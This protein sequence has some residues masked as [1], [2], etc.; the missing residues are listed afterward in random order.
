MSVSQSVIATVAVSIQLTSTLAN[1][2]IASKFTESMPALGAANE[3]FDAEQA[4]RIVGGIPVY[5]KIPFM[6]SLNVP[7]P[8][9][10]S[11]YHYCGGSLINKDWVLTAAH[12]VYGRES[13]VLT[14]QVHVGMNSQ[15]DRDYLHTSKIS[16]VVVHPNYNSNYITNDIALLRLKDSA[17]SDYSF[18][19]LNQ[20]YSVPAD[21]ADV[22]YVGW[23]WLVDQG[24]VVPDQLQAVKVDA[25][26]TRICQYVYG[27][28]SVS[29][30]NVCTYTPDKGACQG[31]SGGPLM[32]PGSD[33]EITS[34][35]QVGIVS[36][37]QKCAGAGS[38]TVTTRVSQYMDWIEYTVQNN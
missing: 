7:N 30:N 31:D 29:S 17:P 21:N 32:A 28:T 27:T 13:T 12:C 36:F 24:R 25:L 38:P 8:N 11:D 1:A 35:K 22:W 4:G 37:G 15:S 26:S 33:G 16:D 34:G 23:G 19:S 9:G 18:V 14:H 2:A 3:Q 10:N 20:D 5:E 6:V